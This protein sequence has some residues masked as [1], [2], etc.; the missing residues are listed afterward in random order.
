MVAIAFVIIVQH[1]CKLLKELKKK[2]L[3]EHEHAVYVGAVVVEICHI[4]MR[5]IK[6]KL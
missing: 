5:S 6:F 2:N 4:E 1:A 3:L